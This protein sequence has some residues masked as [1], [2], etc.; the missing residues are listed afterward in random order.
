VH[1]S[2]NIR[3]NVRYSAQVIEPEHVLENGQTTKAVTETTRLIADKAEHEAAIKVRSKARSFI[4]SVCSATDTC[5]LLCRED[6]VDVLDKAVANARALVDEFNQGAS[7]TTIRLSVTCGRVASDDLEA[8]KAINAEIRDLLADMKSGLESCNVE[9]IREAA[10][11]ARITAGMLSERAQGRVAEAIKAARDAAREI[12]KASETGAAEIDRLTI[13]KIESARTAFLDLDTPTAEIA[14]PT[15]A[16]RAVDFEPETQAVPA[17]AT[18]TRGQVW[19]DTAGTEA[20]IP[21]PTPAT[22][23][24]EL[25][26]TF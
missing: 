24:I 11:K 19:L 9:A 22:R 13:F 8:V 7:L 17:G 18:Y 4:T 15:M 5:G 26:D 2:T 10:N 3:G 21:A 14:T 20:P 12:K 1:L 23:A 6:R 25:Q 16:G